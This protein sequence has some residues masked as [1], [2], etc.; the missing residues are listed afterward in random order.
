MVTIT[1]TDMDEA[2]TI[3]VGGLAVT[4]QSAIDYART[5]QAWWP[6]TAP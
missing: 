5:A 1:V 2:P 4:G 6:P 3:M